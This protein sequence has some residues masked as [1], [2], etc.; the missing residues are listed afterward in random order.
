MLLEVSDYTRSIELSGKLIAMQP[1]NDNGYFLRAVAHERDKQCDK[2]I[3]DYSSSIELFGNK[4]RISS[5]AYEGM[6][7]CYEALGQQCS[8]MVPI[9]NWVALDPAEHDNDQTRS[10]LG[11]LAKEGQCA[12]ESSGSKEE[13]FRRKGKNVIRVKA[14]INGTDGT[15][16]LDTGATYVSI[17][18]SFAESAGIKLTGQNIKIST[19]NGPVDGLLT[20]AQSVK[21]K[22]LEA[23]QVQLVVQLDDF[24]DF[25]DGIDGLI[26]MSFLARYEFAM[27][28][29]TVRIRPRK[30]R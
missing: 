17:K 20:K 26:G 19:A 23:R 2:A 21:L 3:A 5:A 1:N 14:T 6:S 4:E 25:G 12:A 24:Q 10:I 8:A 29:K 15:F 13:V 7:R 16:I 18:K 11:R 27:D 22:S 9:E 28:A 30:M